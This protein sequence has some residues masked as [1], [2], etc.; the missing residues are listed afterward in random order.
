MERGEAMRCPTPCVCGEVVE[1]DDIREIEKRLP[2]GGF[3]VCKRCRCDQCDGTGDCSEC[4]GL[5]Q[6]CTC[7]SHCSDCDGTGDCD[8]CG[9]RGYKIKKD[10]Q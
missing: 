10:E 6:C 2:S 3:M 9:G 5:G 1:L 4:D 8:G 7:G